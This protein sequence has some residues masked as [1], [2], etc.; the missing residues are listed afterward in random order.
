VTKN[1]QSSTKLRHLIQ[2]VLLNIHV[3]EI[4]L[5]YRTIIAIILILSASPSLSAPPS[6]PKC[7]SQ[8]SNE[9]CYAEWLANDGSFFMGLIQKNLLNGRGGAV[10][11]DGSKYIGDF[12]SGRRHGYGV[13]IMDEV[14]NYRGQLSIGTWQNG[15]RYGNTLYSWPN[16]AYFYGFDTGGA[17]RSELSLSDFYHWKRAFNELGLPQKKAVQNFLG[18]AALTS[19]RRIYNYPTDGL[20][21][22]NTFNALAT[23][24]ALM[25]PQHFN[26][27]DYNSAR[28][29]IQQILSTGAAH[30]PFGYII[31]EN[32]PQYLAQTPACPDDV[33]SVRYECFG[34]QRYDDGSIYTGDFANGLPNG[35]GRL[36]DGNLTFVGDFEDGIL[37]GEGKIL[38]EGVVIW[39][40]NWNDLKNNNDE[41]STNS[42]VRVAQPS[43]GSGFTV[44]NDGF[45]ITNEHVAGNCDF[46]TG[47]LNGSN[48]R[49]RVV[50]TDKINDLA[51]LKWDGYNGP[52]VSF[53]QSQLQLGDEIWVSGFPFGDAVSSTLKLTKG[54]VSSLSGIANDYTK[55]Q[56]DAAMQPGNSGGPVLSSDGYLAGVS[57]YK[58]DED[59]TKQNFG[60]TPENTNFAINSQV[61]NL[62]LMANG[63]KVNTEAPTNENIGSI[64]QSV[65]VFIGC[66]R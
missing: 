32:D 11:P 30:S 25:Q 16:G 50:A 13:L 44:T 10:Y 21:G 4:A 36:S 56:I 53:S 31:S 61:V 23:Y 17:I 37:I 54:I 35:E 49:L 22:R 45:I 15:G 57:V 34:S 7:N 19:D 14:S 64:A 46:I 62:F 60:V 28:A 42:E 3:R 18:R 39:E 48:S 12:K 33:T 8:L 1:L 65:T 2:M 51:L 58:L 27:L 63:V 29:V 40:G 38:E 52:N 24:A 59:V 47:S 66:N 6:Y 26:L 43:T 20:W 5:M 9:P 41:A 55:F